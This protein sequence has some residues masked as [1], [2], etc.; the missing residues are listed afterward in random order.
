MF[1]LDD[2]YIGWRQ[3]LPELTLRAGT[4]A[5]LVIDMQ[6]ADASMDHGIMAHR[7][8]IGQLAGLDYYA[9]QL[10][11]I[12]PNIQRLQAACREAGIEVIFTRIQSMSA[13]GRD[14]GGAH[15]DL[16]I[17]C[18]PGSKDAQI[19]EEIAPLDDELVFSKTAGSSFNGTTLD[20]VLGN[21]GI[22]NLVMVGVMTSGCVESAARD[23]KDLGYGVI[24]VADACATWADDMQRASLRVMGEVFAK[25]KSTADV[26][27]AIAA[28]KE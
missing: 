8:A 15:R 9:E 27:A 3:P 19:L 20:Y 14:R 2:P 13:S 11:V 6:Y 22:K 24:V 16:K 12:V 5:L 26:L 10:G 4:T 18:P 23:A 1:N 7:R 25:I 28:A 17:A 21:M